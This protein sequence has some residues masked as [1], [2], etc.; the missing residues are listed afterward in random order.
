MPLRHTRRTAL[1]RASAAGY[2]SACAPGTRPALASCRPPPAPE[3][4]A[5]AAAAEEEEGA[6]PCITTLAAINTKYALAL[7]AWGFGSRA[8]AG[9]A[10]LP[11]D[12]VPG[13][14]EKLAKALKAQQGRW[15]APPA[16]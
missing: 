3:G 1:R 11:T 8:A 15:F 13:L 5:A 14:M 6:A 4:G 9:T 10:M 16:N 12:L 2:D 7:A